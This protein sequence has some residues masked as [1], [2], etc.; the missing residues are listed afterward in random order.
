[1]N[2]PNESTNP[3]ETGG[4]KGGGPASNPLDREALAAGDHRYYRPTPTVSPDNAIT[5]DASQPPDAGEGFP[6]SD[7]TPRIPFPSLNRSNPVGGFILFS[8]E[9]KDDADKSQI[10]G[11]WDDALCSADELDDLFGLIPD[12]TGN[13]WHIINRDTGM[14]VAAHD[15]DQGAYVN[16]VGLPT[17]ADLIA[18][19]VQMK[20]WEAQEHAEALTA[21]GHTDDDVMNRAADNLFGGAVLPDGW[22][23]MSREDFEAAVKANADRIVSGSPEQGV[24][25]QDE[26]T[27]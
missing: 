6:D 2:E 3:D 18:F 21:A 4:R 27:E 26:Q 13:R 11:G 16:G 17:A 1:M 14:I 12:F 5:D 20:L 25:D 7:P 9:A 15:N 19:G 23:E 8:Y 10:A 22:Q 24:S